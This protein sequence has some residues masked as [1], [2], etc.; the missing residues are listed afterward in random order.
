LS[1]VRRDFSR[2]ARLG[3][4]HE[5][6]GFARTEHADAEFFL[7]PVTRFSYSHDPEAVSFRCMLNHGPAATVREHG[8]WARMKE[9]QRHEFHGFSRME[10]S[11]V[12][13]V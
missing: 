13:F 5:N 11:R 12:E 10:T 8:G 7:S 3:S 1:D 2:H 9:G 4:G 6:R